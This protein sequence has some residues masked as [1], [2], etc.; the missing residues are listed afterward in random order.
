ML[1]GGDYEGDILLPS[2]TL[3]RGIGKQDPFAR[4]PNGIVPYEIS[5]DYGKN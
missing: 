4:W 2:D 1:I 5:L 3:H